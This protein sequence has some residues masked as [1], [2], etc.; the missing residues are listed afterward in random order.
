MR[1]S[2]RGVS[3]CAHY[4]GLYTLRVDAADRRIHPQIMFALSV[5][6]P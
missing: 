3:V 6:V 4:P 1:V 5:F 2:A